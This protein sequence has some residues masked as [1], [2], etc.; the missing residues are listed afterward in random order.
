MPVPVFDESEWLRII[1]RPDWYAD[2]MQLAERAK[3]ELGKDKLDELNKRVR[4]FF[5]KAL[6]ENKVNLGVDGPDFDAERRP[7]DTVV[8]HHTSAQPGYRLSYLNAVHLL[9]IYS[10]V[11]AGP[12]YLGRPIWS[13]HFRDGGQTF[14]GYHWIARMDGT[15][16][17]LLNDDQIGWHA[18][19]WNINRRS[20]GICL[21][22]DY[23]NQNPD[24][25]LLKKLAKHIR[26]NYPRAKIIGHCESREGT[27]CPGS[28]FL[29]KW[30]PMLLKYLTDEP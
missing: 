11:F 13:G 20:I 3:K 27:I 15:F 14:W 4:H 18:G 12:E 23:E 28:N 29:E 21:D 19:N 10:P 16:E 7:V 2:Y 1:Q 8:I 6:L 30:K 9:N 5:E 25:D 26:K 24:G 17:R 22:N